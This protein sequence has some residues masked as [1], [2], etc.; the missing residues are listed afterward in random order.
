MDDNERLN[1]QRM[2][3][4]NDVEDCTESIRNKKHSVKIRDDV[5]KMV[6]LKQKYPRLSK[7]NPEQ[8]DSMLVSQCNFLF[9]NY[10]DIFN[11]VKKDE[12]DLK[13]LW[14]FLNVLESIE[15]GKIDQHEG[16]FQ[17]GKLLKSIYIDSALRKAEKLDKKTGKKVPVKPIKEKK[18]T[19]NEYK[20]MMMNNN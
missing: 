3:N 2:I 6:N 5:T 10:T 16:A 11:K 13:I 8:F 12:I 19:W 9:T 18:I 20:K 17:V 7:T 15:E 14:D 4:A 1:L